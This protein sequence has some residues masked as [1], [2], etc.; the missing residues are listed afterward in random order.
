M[1]IETFN[2]QIEALKPEIEAFKASACTRYDKE[3]LNAVNFYL[4]NWAKLGDGVV[5]IIT[6]IIRKQS[7]SQSVDKSTDKCPDITLPWQSNKVGYKR[8]EVKTNSGCCD[9]LFKEEK[10]R[11]LTERYT[12]YSMAFVKYRNAKQIAAGK[13]PET[14]VLPPIVIRDDLFFKVLKACNAIKQTR[15]SYQIR[16]TMRLYKRLCEYPIPF[17]KGLS[18]ASEDFDG[19][20]I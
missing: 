11:V 2:A 18:Y 5:G 7:N 3:R 14:V 8:A 13:E 1:K 17:K 6:E 16:P 9:Y 19:I 12:V 10:S 4:E 15:D 20:I